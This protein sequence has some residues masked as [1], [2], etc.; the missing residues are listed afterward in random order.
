MPKALDSA[1]RENRRSVTPE[2]A[3]VDHGHGYP[4]IDLTPPFVYVFSPAR[5]DV[6]DGKLVPLLS[7]QSL[8]RGANRIDQ[9]K[10]GRW[11]LADWH[12]KLEREG[13]MRIPFAWAPDGESYLVE[14]DSK[15]DGLAEAG[16]AV[17]S[18]F[19]SVYP[20][21]DQS[22]GDVGAYAA[23]LASLVDEGKLP[24]CPTQIVRRKLDA[25]ESKQSSLQHLM[26]GKPSG[27]TARKLEAVTKVVECLA[28]ELDRR[29]DEIQSNKAAPARRRRTKVDEG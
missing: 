9:D 20:G 13:R 21:D 11:R 17:I 18:C 25:A 27:A 4:R 5:W 26:N 24:R 15:P 6:I 12:A 1:T 14:V 2:F 28:A 23:W 19:E 7:K 8:A 3:T 16:V 22:Y 29:R 10:A